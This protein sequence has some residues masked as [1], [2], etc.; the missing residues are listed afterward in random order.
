MDLIENNLFVNPF[1]D[2]WRDYRDSLRDRISD[3]KKI[4]KIH[5]KRSR[6]LSKEM[7]EKR[8]KMNLKQKKLLKRR[9]AMQYRA[10]D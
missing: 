5:H 7:I 8:I 9:K 3:F 4:K 10:N 2:D 6:F 1:Y